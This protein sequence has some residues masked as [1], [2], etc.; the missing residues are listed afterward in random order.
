MGAERPQLGQR[1][2]GRA[3]IRD[4]LKKAARF[5]EEERQ[6][7]TIHLPS[8]ALPLRLDEVERYCGA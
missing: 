7:L 6:K 5:N 4:L 1:L 2:A 3:A 8:R